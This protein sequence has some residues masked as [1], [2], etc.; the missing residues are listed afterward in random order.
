MPLG[1]A[2]SQRVAGNC[3][4]WLWHAD[5]R[6]DGDFYVVVCRPDFDGGYCYDDRQLGI[7]GA[8]A[9]IYRHGSEVAGHYQCVDGY[10]RELVVPQLR[11]YQLHHQ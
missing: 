4:G 6:Q 1:L 5:G 9:D 7:Y 8:G 11:Q 10:H 2:C 3:V